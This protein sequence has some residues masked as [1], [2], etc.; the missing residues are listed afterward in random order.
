MELSKKTLTLLSIILVIFLTSCTPNRFTFK[1][2]R[3]I[4]RKSSNNIM[5]LML[6]SNKRD[7][8]VLYKVS[9]NIKADSTNKYLTR[10]ID[11][12]YVTVRDPKNP[13]VGIAAPQLGI[14]KRIIWVQRFDKEKKPFEVYLNTKIVYYSKE[15]SDGMEGCLSIPGYRGL[16]NRS[17]TI[18]INY[19]FLNQTNLIDT[20]SGFSAIIFQHEIDHL[21]G[22]LY[23]DRIKDK[24]KITKI[25]KSE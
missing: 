3:I 16:V 5:P 18:V 6:V 23:T 4:K 21:E 2:K 25:K 8:V 24:S 17:D 13:G 15:K 14:N 20:V 1:E 22:I 7:S 9:K 10:F 12:M 11:R 19:D